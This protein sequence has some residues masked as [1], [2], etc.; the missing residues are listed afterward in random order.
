VNNGVPWTSPASIRIFDQ[1]LEKDMRGFEYGSGSSTRY[2]AGLLGTLV[3]VEHDKLWYEKVKV[4][5]SSL[6]NVTYVYLPLDL[7]DPDV[8]TSDYPTYILNFPPEHF[9]FI[10]VD[11]RLRVECCMNAVNS[12]KAG[13]IL[14][15]DNSERERYQA[16]F[17][18]L[19]DWKMIQ[20]TT[21]LTD[22]TF[23]FKPE[24]YS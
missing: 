8:K 5:I 4:Q 17:H 19:K 22:T 3:S 7:S 14:V 1:I 24:N 2:F 13:G 21:G 10:L 11:G 9:D 16:I 15:L 12:L 20:T 6:Q 18:L 23:W